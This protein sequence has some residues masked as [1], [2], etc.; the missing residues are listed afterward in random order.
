MMGP[1]EEVEENEQK[2][3]AECHGD[4]KDKRDEQGTENSDQNKQEN[5]ESLGG[6]TFLPPLYLQRYT[7]VAQIIE[8]YDVKKVCLI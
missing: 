8:E 4:H 7:K 3:G 2:A 6:P 1:N 5:E